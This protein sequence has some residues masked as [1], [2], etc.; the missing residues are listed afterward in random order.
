MEEGWCLSQN[1]R[2]WLP[3]TEGSDGAAM[4]G[5]EPGFSAAPAAAPAAALL[6]WVGSK[7]CRSRRCW[8]PFSSRVRVP[9]PGCASDH[10]PNC[11]GQQRRAGQGKARFIAGSCIGGVARWDLVLFEA[12]NYEWLCISDK[13]VWTPLCTAA[14]FRGQ[15]KPG[16]PH[17][18]YMR[19]HS[20]IFP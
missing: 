4:L 11:S 5:R 12:V 10:I 13:K 1:S 8:L 15:G 7:L 19:K 18:R 16:V 20:F 3:G 9:Q 6:G 17:M 2:S 14:H